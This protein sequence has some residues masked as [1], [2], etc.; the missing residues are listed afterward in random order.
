MTP[1]LYPIGHGERHCRSAATCKGCVEPLKVAASRSPPM[2]L[3]TAAPLLTHIT[4]RR[5]DADDVVVCA[6]RMDDDKHSESRAQAE[7]NE[8]VFIPGVSSGRIAQD[9]QPQQSPTPGSVLDNHS[10]RT[11]IRLTSTRRNSVV[12]NVIRQHAPLDNTLPSWVKSVWQSPAPR[13][14]RSS[15]ANRSRVQNQQEAV[16]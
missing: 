4:D 5:N 16:A 11:T 1:L 13:H 9:V 15:P 2:S 10:H 6:V 7:Q 8:P 12:E 14:P 3:N